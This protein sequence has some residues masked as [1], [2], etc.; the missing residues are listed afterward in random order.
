MLRSAMGA[1]GLLAALGAATAEAQVEPASEAPA[2]VAFTLDSSGSLR[3]R[4]IEVTRRLARDVLAAL[5]A[6]SRVAVLSFDDQSRIL[7]EATDDVGAIE[8]ALSSVQIAGR[9]TALHD[10]L[11]DASEYLVTRQEP[12]RAIV[13]V[14]DGKDENSAVLLED[15]LSI[16]REQSIPVFAVGV[17]RIQDQVLRRIGK[18]TGGDYAP[19]S[20]ASGEALARAIRA[21]PERRI[22]TAAP[23]EAPAAS[24]P[25]APEP[26]APSRSLRE[27]LLWAALGLG[28]VLA[29]AAGVLAMRGRRPTAASVCSNCGAKLPAPDAT[30]LDCGRTSEF[31]AVDADATMLTHNPM[32]GTVERTM[33]LTSNPV[34]RISQG[35]SAG[36]VYSL[37]PTTTVSVGRGPTND[38]VLDDDAV[39]GQHCRFRPEDGRFLVYDLESTNGTYV[40]DRRIQ[41]HALAEGDTIRIGETVFEF[42][43]FGK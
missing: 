9:F 43:S 20:D 25:P 12:R 16:A 5:P 42:H 28:L 34:L 21:L 6:G 38:I 41:R 35:P 14:T 27:Y 2:V 24:A 29:A 31:D 4:D 1:V 19:A 7:L 15:G 33:V 40:N 22:E 13:L 39:S 36:Q 26:V 11:F 3:A 23:A 10:A 30:C 18:L 37:S 8:T 17:G 32:A